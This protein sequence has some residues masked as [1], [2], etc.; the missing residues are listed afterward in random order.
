MNVSSLE[1]LSTTNHPPAQRAF[2]SLG[3]AV[4]P[5][6]AYRLPF[7][8][9]RRGRSLKHRPRDASHAVVTALALGASPASLATARF[10]FASIAARVASINAESFF[11]LK[12]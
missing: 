2:P 8:R 1:I 6:T 12:P 11:S 10:R 3:R 4:V 7:N 9:S 5:E